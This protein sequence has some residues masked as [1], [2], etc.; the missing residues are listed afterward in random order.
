ALDLSPCARRSWRCNAFVPIALSDPSLARAPTSAACSPGRA[1][2]MLSSLRASMSEP[3][4][5]LLNGERVDVAG[6]PPQTTLLEFL[7]DERRLTGTKEGCAEGD[8][9]ACTVVIAERAGA[10][11]AWKP[12]NARIRRRP[13]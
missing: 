8:C 12:V 5:F 13:P 10:R 6:L 4:R 3:V 1:G 2:A 11:I 9:G 7:R